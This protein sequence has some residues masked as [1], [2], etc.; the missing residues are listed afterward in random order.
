VDGVRAEFRGPDPE[1]E[2][3]VATVTW[4][5]DRVRVDADDPDV[6][7]ALE[8]A[9]RSTPIVTDDAAYRPQ[10]TSGDVVITPGDLDWFRAATF[11]RA[12]AESGLR[13]RLIPGIAEG[14]FDPAS[15][16]RPFGE[17]IERLTR[18]P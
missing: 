2:T 8:R 14:G 12:P 3:V 9:Y 17:Q 4:S 6:R 11:V 1:D 7:T 10:G 15:N 13:A 16:Y 5:G 18:S